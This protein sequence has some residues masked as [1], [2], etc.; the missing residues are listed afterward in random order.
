MVIKVDK[1]EEFIK[2][3]RKLITEY[4]SEGLLKRLKKNDDRELWEMENKKQM[5]SEQE[6]ADGFCGK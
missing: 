4:D 6:W 2:S 1:S 5:L 3:G